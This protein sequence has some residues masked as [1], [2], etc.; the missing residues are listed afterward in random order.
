MIPPLIEQNVALALASSACRTSMM[1]RPTGHPVH[2][3][4]LPDILLLLV[5]GSSTGTAR[6]PS[7]I[8]VVVPVV[9][10]QNLLQD[11][12]SV[13]LPAGIRISVVSRVVWVLQQQQ[14]RRSSHFEVNWVCTANRTT[15]TTSLYPPAPPG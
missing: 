11:V 4:P 15:L 9:S 2:A 6:V 10:G 8:V 5:R 13:S 12:R 3:H 14:Q 1:S 7:I